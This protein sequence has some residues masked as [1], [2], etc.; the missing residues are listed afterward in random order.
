[1]EELIGLRHE[2]GGTPSTP[3]TGSGQADLAGW[4]RWARWFFA[5]SASRRVSED[6]SSIPVSAYVDR[7]VEIGTVKTLSE[8]VQVLPAHP[9]AQARLRAVLTQEVA[10]AESALSEKD[11]LKEFFYPVGSGQSRKP[12]LLFQ[13]FL[14]RD[15]R[16]VSQRVREYLAR[17]ILL[18]MDVSLPPPPTLVPRTA[19]WKY[20]DQGQDLGT[21]WRTLGYDDSAWLEGPGTLGYDESGMVAI[22]TPVSFG[23]DPANRHIT[24]YFRHAFLAPTNGLGLDVTVLLRSDLD[25]RIVYLNGQEIIR[26]NLPEGPVSAKTL[27]QGARDTW[28]DFSPFEVS[29]PLQPGT[30]VLAV[31]SHQ[32]H[33]GCG[34]LHFDLELRQ[35]SLGL[36]FFWSFSPE[37]FQAEIQDLLSRV[38]PTLQGDWTNR[39]E[40]AFTA[41]PSS[42]PE[43]I[44]GNWRNWEVRAQLQADLTHTAEARQAYETCLKLLRAQSTSEAIARRIETVEKAMEAL[45]K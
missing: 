21:E 18:G 34:D 26:Q 3:S 37:Q 25:G 38:P 39:F 22:A 1:V 30:N 9:T 35:G 41:T 7:L 14:H 27:G 44:Q 28:N 24:T 12:A 4:A 19:V 20:H 17:R 5:D 31:E 6:P 2:V 29:Q 16:G 10:A 43:S 36:S 15:R 32:S 11:E 8:A 23:S 33:P 13:E 42:A 40:F 45:P